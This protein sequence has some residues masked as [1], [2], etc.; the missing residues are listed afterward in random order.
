MEE[1]QRLFCSYTSDTVL[2]YD[3]MPTEILNGGVGDQTLGLKRFVV[4]P[5]RK[6]K[7]C[8]SLVL[9]AEQTLLHLIHEGH[10]LAR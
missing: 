5:T 2:N 4:C 10:V 9:H 1:F 6:K 7:R 3:G 8:K